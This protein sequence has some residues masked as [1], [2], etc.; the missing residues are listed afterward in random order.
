MGFSRF[1]CPEY[2]CQT[3]TG[4][5]VFR[6]RVPHDYSYLI[7]KHEIRYSLRTRCTY[8]ARKCIASILP[9]L[10]DLF[11]GIRRGNFSALSKVDLNRTIKKGIH[12]SV[13][14]P[15]INN[16]ITIIASP[17]VHWAEPPSAEAVTRSTTAAILFHITV[18]V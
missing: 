5:F 4:V 3:N 2:L 7:N 12:L 1:R 10:K 15:S 16:R 17:V 9:F 6:I 18:R 14:E 11:E 13:R 8:S